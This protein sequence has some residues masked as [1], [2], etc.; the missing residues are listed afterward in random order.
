MNAVLSRQFSSLSNYNY[1]VYFF[2]QTVSLI[3]TWMQTTGMAW[4]VLELTGS[5]DAL[6]MVV[7]LQFLPITIFSLFGGVFADRLPK[8]SVL[9]VTQSIALIQAL[10]MGVLA[11]GGV[12]ELWHVYALALLL[13]TVNAFDGPVRQSFVVELV[14]KDHLVNAVALN[15]GIFNL[16]R[17]VGPG[18]AGVTI[19]IIGPEAS[20]FLNAGSFV[21]V[22]IAYAAMRPGQL[23][24]ARKRAADGSVLRQIGE[25]ISYSVKTPAL[26]RLFLM[27]AIIGTFGFNFIVVIP[28]VAE[29]VLD[30]GPE[31][32]GLL[33]SAMGIGSLVA[34]LTLAASGKAST[35]V[36]FIAASAFCVL[37]AAVGISEV[38]FLTFVLLLLFGVASLTF[39]TSINTTIQLIVPD[40]YRGRVMSI[41]FLLMA[42]STPIGG[43]VTGQLADSVGVRSTL[44]IE[45][46]L[47]GVGVVLALAYSRL[48]RD[49][50]ET[51]ASPASPPVHAGR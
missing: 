50:P 4:L 6:G 27:I 3:G 46:V 48:L 9:I 47:C 20:F 43:L 36:M 44:V 16:A 30:V 17:I 10:A 25:G 5:A 42:G 23:Y 7:A 22:L 37:L 45:A 40:E 8:R 13:G 26:A 51:Q 28:L 19:G 11:A 29:F 34:A 49:K 15:S 1:R 31:K 2:G 38:Y 32:F 12:I 14:G 33:T 41:F 24:E 21:A 18:I 35:R 39:S